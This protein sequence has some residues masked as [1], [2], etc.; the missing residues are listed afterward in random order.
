MVKLKSPK[1][2]Y[3][4][5]RVIDHIRYSPSLKIAQDASG[6]IIVSNADEKYEVMTNGESNR[7][8]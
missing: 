1:Q 7:E 3:E 8:R 6:T 2:K 4:L 5:A